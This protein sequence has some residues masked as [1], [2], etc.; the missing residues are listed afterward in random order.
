MTENSVDELL[1]DFF[2]YSEIFIQFWK[3]WFI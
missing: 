1:K 3:K 2:K